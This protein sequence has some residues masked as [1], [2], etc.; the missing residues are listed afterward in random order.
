MFAAPTEC[1]GC[2]VPDSYNAVTPVVPPHDR[3]TRER[4]RF[5]NR[6]SIRYSAKQKTV[7]YL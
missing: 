5:T 3:P 2:G 7:C 1:S 4:G 6:S